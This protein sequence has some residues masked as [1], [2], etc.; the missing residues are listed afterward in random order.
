MTTESIQLGQITLSGKNVWTL[1][2]RY[3]KEQ[4]ARGP[5]PVPVGNFSVFLVARQVNGQM[6]N[7]P[8]KVKAMIQKT[9]SG[10]IVFTGSAEI[11]EG[12]TLRRAT[13]PGGIY[14][15]RLESDYYQEKEDQAEF[16]VQAVRT[17]NVELDPS[18]RYPFPFPGA[19]PNSAAPTLLR[20]GV[21]DAGGKG[22]SGATVEITAPVTTWPFAKYR[23]DRFGQWVLVI[24]DDAAFGSDGLLTVTV[25]V[26]LPDNTT[27]TVAGVK[28]VRRRE[29]GLQQTAFR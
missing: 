24:P 22:I 25:K 2:D 15:V 26:T 4:G 6:Q 17:L 20:G 21:F 19:L 3:A 11:G 8:E 13:I 7:I 27:F 16:G 5:F 10:A 1:V 18:Y 9:M 14:R 29:A 23:A 28:V 12:A